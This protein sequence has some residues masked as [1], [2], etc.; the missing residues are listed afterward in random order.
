MLYNSVRNGVR[1]LEKNVIQITK[2]DGSVEEWSFDKLLS[3]VTKAGLPMDKGE[4]LAKQIEEWLKNQ[5]LKIVSSTDIRD[6]VIEIMKVMEP[7]TASVYE[8]YRK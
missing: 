8:A 6:K 1:K 2:R 3:S 5:S 7:M 4:L